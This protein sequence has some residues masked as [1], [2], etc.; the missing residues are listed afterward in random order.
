M[1]DVI[2]GIDPGSTGAVSLINVRTRKIKYL[3]LPTTKSQLD[4]FKLKN[5]LKKISPRVAMCGIERNSA[6][7]GTDEKGEKRRFGSTQQM[8]KGWNEGVIFGMLIMSEIPYME[9]SPRKWQNELYKSFR[10]PAS[11]T[12]TKD[13]AKYVA[14][15]MFPKESFIPTERS[16]KPHDGC[17]DATLIAEYTR[18]SYAVESL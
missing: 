10:I 11:I 16:S 6:L 5:F 2:M 4:T 8:K 18:R 14:N 9:F 3:K 15:R 1:R 7:S 12:D 13:K 17:I